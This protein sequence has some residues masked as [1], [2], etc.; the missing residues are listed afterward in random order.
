MVNWIS[1]SSSL[2]FW[3]VEVRISRSISDSPLEFEITR[4]DCNIKHFFCEQ[5]LKYS[6]NNQNSASTGLLFRWDG[7]SLQMSHNTWKRLRL[8]YTSKRSDKSLP[9]GTSNPW[10]LRVHTE[11]WSDCALWLESLII[12]PNENESDCALW[13]GSALGTQLSYIFIAPDKSLFSSKKYWYFLL[14]FHK[15]Y[16]VVLFRSTF[17][18]CF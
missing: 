17:P 4:V 3:Y 13:S 7:S 2:Q 11:D 6:A 10:I 16:V 18:R 12:A 9:K 15:T 5:T 14:F 1:F 8:A